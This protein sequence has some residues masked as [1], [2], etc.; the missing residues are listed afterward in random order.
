MII[1]TRH[2]DTLNK[3]ITFFWGVIPCNSV[4]K[5]QHFEGTLEI[6]AAGSPKRC[7]LPTSLHDFT[8]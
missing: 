6:K 4:D 1:T 5:D 2:Q 3:A 7:S 8:S